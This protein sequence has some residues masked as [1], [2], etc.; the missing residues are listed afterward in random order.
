VQ[1]FTTSINRL[2]LSK[3]KNSRRQSVRFFKTPR[4]CGQFFS[5][6]LQTK[7]HHQVRKKNTNIGH[8]APS[9]LYWAGRPAMRVVQA[10]YWLKDTLAADRSRILNRLTQV[11]SEPEHGAVM[12]RDLRDGWAHLPAWMQTLL[13]D[14]LAMNPVKEHTP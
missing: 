11:L 5:W 6:S 8:T 4:W 3:R 2:S 12:S 13:R 10:L 1:L 7:S 9:R 14:Q